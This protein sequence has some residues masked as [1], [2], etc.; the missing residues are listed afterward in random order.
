MLCALILFVSE[1]TYSR[2]WTTKFLRMTSMT[3]LFTLRVFAKNL[4]RK[5]PKKYFFF[6][7]RFEVWTGLRTRIL[8]CL[9][10]QHTSQLDYGDFSPHVYFG[11][12]EPTQGIHWLTAHILISHMTEQVDSMFLESVSQREVMRRMNIAIPLIKSQFIFQA[13][14]F[15]VERC[16]QLNLNRD[17]IKN[18]T[19]SNTI[20]Q[21]DL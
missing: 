5:S 3:C 15:A 18:R 16:V 14:V 21:P 7:F 2:L 20:W 8:L 4:L 19:Y 11:I 13:E 6:I 1:G 9:V 12:S 10:S 17:G